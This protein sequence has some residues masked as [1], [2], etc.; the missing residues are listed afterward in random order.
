MARIP[1]IFTSKSRDDLVAPGGQIAYGE[2]LQDDMP[3]LNEQAALR[4][5]L[6]RK[7]SGHSEQ[8]LAD[9]LKW[10]QS[11][12]SQKLTGKTPITLDELSALCMMLKMTPVEAV[13]DHGLEFCAEMTPTELRALE[14]LRLLP[15][16]ERDAIITILR[17]KAG[18]KPDRHAGPLP[19]KRITNR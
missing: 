14:N 12:V 8:D 6:A 16:N 2:P 3:T 5:E 4:L 7:K 9:M 19:K 13:R 18:A 15:Q 17:A 10:S 1:R 11:R